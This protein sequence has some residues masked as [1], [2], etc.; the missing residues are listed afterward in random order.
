L[1]NAEQDKEEAQLRERAM[2]GLRFL[3]IQRR[4]QPGCKGWELKRE[5]GRNYLQLLKLV[6]SLASEI[7][8][9]LVSIPD[10]DFPDDPDR[11]RYLLV[12]KEPL[13]GRDTGSWLRMEEAASLAI[14]L[15]HL[16]VKG[17][18]DSKAV[19]VNILKEKLPEWR[20]QQILS[21]LTRLGYIEEDSGYIKVGW[22]SKVE[23]D[24]DQLLTAILSKGPDGD[25]NKDS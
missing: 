11:S 14:V 10:E 19:L 5:M 17:E 2:H 1:S 15:S 8:L 12:S 7:G 21:K 4:N 3:L 23:V 24:R 9:K 20:A 13:N 16:F 18:V 25:K 6:G 22:R